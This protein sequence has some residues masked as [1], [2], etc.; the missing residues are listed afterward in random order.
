MAKATLVVLTN[1][2]SDEAEDEYNR[3]YSEV[4]LR[5]VV[6]LDGFVSAQRYRFIDVAAMPEMPKTHRYLALYEFDGDDLEATAAAL[7]A[8]AGTD[9]MVIS[10]ALDASTAV[11]R[12]AEP[13]GAPVTAVRA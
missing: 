11:A 12:W 6:A 5:D 7:G 9:A 2:V 4:H 13:I 10:P 3:W 8:A 1:P